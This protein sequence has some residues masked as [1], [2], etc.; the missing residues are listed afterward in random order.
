MCCFRFSWVRFRAAR[1]W[2]TQD[3]CVQDTPWGLLDVMTCSLLAAMER[4]I[5]ARGSRQTLQFLPSPSTAGGNGFGEKLCRAS[6][7]LNITAVHRLNQEFLSSTT[8]SSGQAFLL[9]SA[10]RKVTNWPQFFS[11]LS[12]IG[13]K[14]NMNFNKARLSLLNNNKYL[15]ESQG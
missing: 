1:Q 12:S 14:V 4:N 6:S 15:K 5:A 8:N 13:K 9:R 3:P 10:K 7:K 2:P 11:A